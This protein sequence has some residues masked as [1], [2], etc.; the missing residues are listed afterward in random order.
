MFRFYQKV[1]QLQQVHFI[2]IF[3]IQQ[4]IFYFFFKYSK[5]TF[6]RND[7]GLIQN[8]KFKIIKSGLRFKISFQVHKEL[9][10]FNNRDNWSISSF[11]QPNSR[12]LQLKD[13]QNL[14]IDL[15][16][17]YYLKDLLKKLMKQDHQLKL[18]TLIKTFHKLHKILIQQH[19]LNYLLII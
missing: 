3:E 2:N 15:L 14:K 6:L 5:Y 10:K 13:E 4:K 7:Q 12:F 1:Q 11:L 19:I 9:V 8:C 18:V 17:L 16:L